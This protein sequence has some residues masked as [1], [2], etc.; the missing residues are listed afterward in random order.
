[1]RAG[2][3]VTAVHVD[4]GLRPDSGRDADVARSTA[5]RLEIP[6]RV[7]RAVV[8]SGPNVEERA[9]LA[10]R[11]AVGPA[12][13]TGHTADDQAETLLL[14]L[15][16]GSGARGLAGMRPG[17]THPILALRRHETHELCRVAGLDTV[18]DPTND[19]RRIRRNRV[20][21]DVLPLLNEIADRD[22]V[23]LLERATHLVRADDDLLEELASRIDATDARALAAAAPPLARRAVRRWLAPDGHPPDLATV[24]RVLAVAAENAIGC[25][26]GGGRRVLRSAGRLRI[27]ATPDVDHDATP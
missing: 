14:A 6:L 5:D 13:M 22:V 19:D 27:E 8:E 15:L 18:D 20:R 26:V 23:P 24:E 17:P 21:H 10:R 11:R 16:R 12:A 25:E 9:R 4:H 1:M 3:T 2:L 7:E